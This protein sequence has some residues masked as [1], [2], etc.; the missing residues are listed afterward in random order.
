MSRSCK[1][2]PITGMTTAESDKLFKQ[3]EHRRERANV[4]I[5]LNKG[6]DLPSPRLFGD[7]ANSD[8][9]GKQFNRKWPKA[10]RK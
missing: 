9:D 8:K 1:K 2:F 3:V 6:D 4:K 5:A 10:L 7:P